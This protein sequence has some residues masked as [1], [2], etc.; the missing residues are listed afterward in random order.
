MRLV[1]GE[2]DGGDVRLPVVVVVLPLVRVDAGY[3]RQPPHEGFSMHLAPARGRREASA[4]A[5]SRGGV[6][7]ACGPL[8][9]QLGMCSFISEP[10]PQ[11]VAL[12]AFT[13]NQF[14]PCAYRKALQSPPTSVQ[15]QSEPFQRRSHSAGGWLVGSLATGGSFAWGEGRPDQVGRSCEESSR[16][17]RSLTPSLPPSL[18]LSSSSSPGTHRQAALRWPLCAATRSPQP[19]R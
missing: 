12:I 17:S 4:A 19:P 2:R 15:S 9:R 8:A 3:G 18:S 1:G 14:T 7:P 6:G 10:T 16:L 13:S 5:S 11:F